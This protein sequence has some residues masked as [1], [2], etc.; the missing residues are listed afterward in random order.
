MNR[1]G[2]YIAF[3][4]ALVTLWILPG[5]SGT[6]RLADGEVL[7]NGASIKFE[8]PRLV[9]HKGSLATELEGKIKSTENTKLM[10]FSRPSLWLYQHIKEPKKKKGLRRWLK[11]KLG[12]EPVLVE[13]SDLKLSALYM[14]KYLLDNG[15]FGSKVNYEVIPKGKTARVV[16]HVTTHGQYTI[17][18][19]YLP[20]DSGKVGHLIHQ[21]KDH[22][23]TKPCKAYNLS[24]LKTDREYITHLARNDGYFDF[25]KEQVF[26]YADTT[27]KDRKL[28]IYF[29]LK[30]PNDTTLTIRYYIRNI[31]VYTD[32][33]IELED[34][35]LHYD[36]TY[37]D[38]MRFI[39][40]TNWISPK[41]IA[42]NIVLEKGIP[43]SQTVHEQSINHLL[44]LQVFKFVN[45]QYEKT[46]T[47]SLDVVV[48]LTPT[49][50][51][52]IKVGVE[53]STSNRS[54]FG[55]YFSVD[56]NHRNLFKGGQRLEVNV[57]AGAELQFKSTESVVNIINLNAEVNYIIPRF[58]TPFPKVNRKTVKNLP[59][60]RI[61]FTENFQKWITYYTINSVDLAYGYDWQK[62]KMH[63]SLNILNINKVKVLST[64]SAFDDL[65]AASDLLQVSFQDILIIG[66]EYTFWVSTQDKDNPLRNY[67]YFRG[68]AETSGNVPYGLFRL[69]SPNGSQPYSIIKDPFSQFVR[70]EADLRHYHPINN[71]SK[72]VSRIAGGIG[73]A[74]G[75]STTL[76][77]VKQFFIGGPNSVRAFPY[78][79]VGPGTYIS[80]STSTTSLD[81]AG[82]FKLEMNLEYRFGVFSFLKG[83][84]FLDAG[85]VWLVHADSERPGSQFQ[86]KDFY[87]ELA[88]GTGLGA[89][90]D[91]DFFV[92]RFDVGLPLRKP[93]LDQGQRWTWQESDF[94][95]HSWRKDNFTYNLAIGYPF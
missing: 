42:R 69:A 72:L 24:D 92:I 39:S 58:I 62:S 47:D 83:A 35:D 4:W 21:Y 19:V 64:T 22:L 80:D 15:Y 87:R 73:E 84:V 16:Y 28:D 70:F 71:N 63:H 85:N 95:K 18:N 49:E 81:R 38:G 45:I 77:Y 36:T 90:L 65:L 33:S 1:R 26:Y 82:T 32:H 89:R 61:T 52:D 91:F 17:N 9:E 6:R 8:N 27:G 57:S 67:I 54:N 20:P 5:C 79:S 56:Y 30:D 66:P 37:Q 74:Y 93:Y 51:Q 41:A 7:Y 29:R 12:E 55:S 40:A 34:Y 46:G 23:E 59:V 86:V 53:A 48:Q 31:T 78:Q 88:L 13:E 14:E 25:T 2:L 75:N 10:G 50:T 11:Y 43:F 60:S 3:G 44:A 68:H 76:P 94:M